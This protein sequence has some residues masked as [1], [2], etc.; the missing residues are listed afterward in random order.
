[1]NLTTWLRLW[2]LAAYFIG[3]ALLHSALASLMVKRGCAKLFGEAFHRWYRLLFVLI[4]VATLAP[5]LGLL[6]VSPIRILYAVPMPWRAAMLA[7]Q[8]AAG[9]ALVIAT[10]Q[11]GIAHFLGVA[12]A[13]A[14]HP[15]ASQERGKFQ[16][17]G[18]FRYIRHPLYLFAALVLWLTP[19]MTYGVFVLNILITL[20]FIISSIQEER[21]LHHEFGADYEVYR[22]QVPR[23]LPWPGRRYTPE[24]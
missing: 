12:Q 15:Q 20:Y 2:P 18:F 1:M 24:E 16:V 13:L 17:R 19:V 7:G 10:W 6:A 23:F 11:A 21:V 5:L 8:I 22:E 9:I 3:W 4:S 14:E